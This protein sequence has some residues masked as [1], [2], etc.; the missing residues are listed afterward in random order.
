[1]VRPIS[2][3]SVAVSTGRVAYVYLEDHVPRRWGMSRKAAKDP[4]TA[5][6]IVGSW[7]DDLAPDL[8]VSENPERANRKGFGVRAILEV[9]GEVFEQAAGLNMC[10]TRV[11]PFENKF[12]E[13]QV[14]V[15]RYP[16]L[17]HLCPQKPP[18]WMPEPRNISYFEALSF[19]EQLTAKQT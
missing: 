4:C 2:V 7:V 15:R 1:M 13:A 18:I 16:M 8:L 12:E 3:L 14:L 19:A 11:Q 10:L 17:K 9:I 5:A 6:R